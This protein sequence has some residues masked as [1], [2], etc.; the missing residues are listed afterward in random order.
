MIRNGLKAANSLPNA[1]NFN[2]YTCF[3]TFNEIRNVQIKKIADSMQNIVEK[4]GVAGNIRQRDVEEKFDLI[5]ES[6]DI[7]LDRAVSTARII[8]LCSD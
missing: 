3:P 1:D 4:S 2:Y 7:F 5:L 6:N 8:I